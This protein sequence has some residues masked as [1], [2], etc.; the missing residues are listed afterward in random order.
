MHESMTTE[1][2][3]DLR[4]Y[5]V[6]LMHSD[7][8]CA[9]MPLYLHK[10][11]VN[12]CSFSFYSFCS[13][14]VWH[15][16]C[17]LQG[18]ADTPAM[19][20]MSGTTT[21]STYSDSKQHPSLSGRG[22][23]SLTSTSVSL[24]YDHPS[25]GAAQDKIESSEEADKTGGASSASKGASSETSSGSV[26]QEGKD[27]MGGGSSAIYS[28]GPR[29]SG[30]AAQ[31]GNTESQGDASTPA[32]PSMSGTST[33]T[34]YSD[35]SKHRPLIDK[36]G[37]SKG[38]V[39]SNPTSSFQG[40]DEGSDNMGGGSSAIYSQGPRQG[41]GSSSRDSAGDA[42]TPA[43]PSM[44]GSSAASIYAQRSG[45]RALSDSTAS[46]SGH[47]SSGN[48]SGNSSGS[49]GQGSSS[50]NHD[51]SGSAKAGSDHISGVHQTCS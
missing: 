44:S 34:S 13:L 14:N 47:G 43:M 29:K 32:M 50:G 19:P 20:S 35:S 38:G 7:L 8:V 10:K 11:I 1:W 18:D 51:R 33:A 46:G 15:V 28:Q 37:S 6:S 12:V 2:A 31:G 30:D 17:E 41:G 9:S 49:S 39:T 40:S 26:S 21:A 27:N 16:C 42:S 45:N 5:H 36:G 4:Y 25:K 23:S 3:F 24:A 48:G 22:K